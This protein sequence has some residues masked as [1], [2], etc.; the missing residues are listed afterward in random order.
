MG[1]REIAMIVVSLILVGILG[2]AVAPSITASGDATKTSVVG[3]EIETVAKASKMWMTNNSIRGD[4]TGITAEAISGTLSTMSVA[5]SG[6][7]SKLI[8][9][10]ISS[11]NYEISSTTTNSTDDSVQI[12]I[13]GLTAISGAEASLKTTLTNIYGVL[14]VSEGSGGTSSDGIL[15]IKVKG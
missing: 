1:F 12:T 15:I 11:I 2:L 4:F 9:K 13:S 14:N 8:S 10:V 7:S 3:S 5:G 6:S